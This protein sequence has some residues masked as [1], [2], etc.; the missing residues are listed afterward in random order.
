M[1]SDAKVS[2]VATVYIGKHTGGDDAEKFITSDF[3]PTTVNFDKY[4]LIKKF[5]LNGGGSTIDLN[6]ASGKIKINKK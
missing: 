6:T 1:P 3:D 5:I 2:I 4:N